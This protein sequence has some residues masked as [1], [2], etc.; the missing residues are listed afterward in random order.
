M[1]SFILEIS[2]DLGS[3]LSISNCDLFKHCLVCASLMESGL[4]PPDNRKKCWNC[5]RQRHKCDGARPHCQK[6][7]AKGVH[8][9]GYGKLLRW[10]DGATCKGQMRSSNV[11]LAVTHNRKYQRPEPVFLAY[12]PKEEKRCP[13]GPLA[14][15]KGLLRVSPAPHTSLTDPLLQDMPHIDRYLLEYCQ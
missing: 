11:P 8:C 7:A 5:Q 15:E 12:Q 6:C 9:L 4:S 2:L 13:D 10:V 1:R 14:P 3:G